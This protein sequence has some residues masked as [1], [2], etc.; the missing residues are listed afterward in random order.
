MES[1]LAPWVIWNSRGEGVGKAK[2]LK[3]NYEAKFEFTVGWGGVQIKTFRGGVWMERFPPS[4][5]R[6]SMRAQPS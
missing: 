3:E 1:T 4:L 2:V 5:M 6:R